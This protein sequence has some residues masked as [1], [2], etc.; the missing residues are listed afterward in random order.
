MSSTFEEYIHKIQQNITKILSRPCQTALANDILDSDDDRASL[1]ICLRMKQLQMKYGEIWQMVIGEYE[2][3]TNLGVGHESGL[4]VLSIKNKMIFEI[5]NHHNTDNASS[6]KS[7]LDKLIKY[8]RNNPGFR[9]V[10]GIVNDRI[11]NGICKKL[12]HDDEEIEYYS[13]DKLFT[14][15]FGD[16]KDDVI[17]VVKKAVQD[18]KRTLIYTP[19]I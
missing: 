10:Y 18:Y 13:G 4:D 2:G 15:V 9:G 5:K 11:P 14:L 1:S 7:N 19:P 12:F 6:R 17:T 16:R 3:F 8:K